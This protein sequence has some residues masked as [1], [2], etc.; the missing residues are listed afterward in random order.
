MDQQRTS[1]QVEVDF[2]AEVFAYS[3]PFAGRIRDST[4]PF[5]VAQPVTPKGDQQ[6]ASGF[7]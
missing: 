6:P 7:T 4:R 1:E 2:R 3:T 5:E